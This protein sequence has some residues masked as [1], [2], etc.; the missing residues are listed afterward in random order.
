MKLFFQ[1][2]I[3]IGIMNI[4]TAQS[5][6][7]YFIDKTMRIDYH[8]IGDNK[9][10]L[11]TIDRIYEYGIWSGSKKNLVDS[12]NNGKYF[13]KVYSKED[14]KLIFSRGFD[15]YFGEYQLSENA[16][17]GIKKAFHE[18]AIIPTPKN[19]IRFAI[20]KRNDK[21][22]LVEI[23]TCEINPAS[24]DIVRDSF[25]D[26]NIIV[27]KSHYSGEPHTKLDIAIIGEG[28]TLQEKSKFEKD[29]KKFT[30]IILRNEPYKSM[31]Q[32]INI[33]GVLKPSVDSGVDEPRANIFKNTPVNCTFNSMGSERYLL[34][35]DNKS[36]RDIA[37]SVPYDALTI[38]VNHNRYGGGG[39]YNFYCTFTSDNQ[40][41]EYL[42]VH[43][44]GHSFGGL[45]DEYYTSATAYDQM[46]KPDLEP[47]E[48]NITALLDKDN[49]KWK[50]L[51]DKNTAIP[52]AWAK[53]QF[54][55][56][57]FAWQKVRTELNNKVAELKR[58]RAPKEEIKAAEEYY[59]EQD[60]KRSDRVDSYLK[61]EPN[62]G[63]VGAYEGAGYLTTGMFRPMLDCIMF[64]KG[65]KPYCLVCQDAVK[66]RIMFYAE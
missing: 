35:E 56:D 22:E 15:S 62:F 19:D 40:F 51:V 34:T 21:Q 59:A 14:G 36:L 47:L 54:D 50:H 31:Q 64:S 6:D 46:F 9:L 12:F 39:I 52:T 37:A 66:K 20:E 27:I 2:L 42:F 53:E 30:D 65:A 49:L 13:I 3:L 16:T 23:F 60:K 26:P 10:E 57:D 28:Y 55:K 25:V 1:T 63:K 41:D 24:V 18:S 8:H 48:A 4:L 38:M 33:Y 17:N 7:N 58:N 5:F 11:V 29:L 44:F 61:N 43:E 32:H 45:A